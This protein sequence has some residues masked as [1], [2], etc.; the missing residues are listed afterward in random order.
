MYA[1]VA[2]C[3]PFVAVSAEGVEQVLQAIAAI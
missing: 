2:R 1:V 3:T